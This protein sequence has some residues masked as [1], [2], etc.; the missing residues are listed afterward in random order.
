MAFDE[1]RLESFI[2]ENTMRA[3]HAIAPNLPPPPEER[4]PVKVIKPMEHSKC[5]CRRRGAPP[6]RDEGYG[7]QWRFLHFRACAPPSISEWVDIWR[8][9]DL[10]TQ[11]LHR[12]GCI[13]RNL[14]PGSSLR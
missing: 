13:A 3:A 1:L 4:L 9:D 7:S 5:R 14:A 2:C 10:L 6:R 12:N 11:E 8:I